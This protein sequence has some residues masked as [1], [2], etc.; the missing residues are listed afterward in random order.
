[1]AY[2]FLLPIYKIQDQITFLNKKY[3]A[4]SLPLSSQE[5]NGEP[6]E[7]SLKN[8]LVESMKEED[9]R[10]KKVFYEWVNERPKDWVELSEISPVLISAIVVSEDAKFA[11][12]LGIDGQELEKVILEYVNAQG[13][14]SE[15]QKLRGAS[16]ISQQLV[17]NLFLSSKKDVTRKGREILMS[18]YLESKVP[19]WKILETYLNIIEYGKDLYGIK[20]ASEFY[21]KK[22]PKDL[23]AREAAFLAMLLPSPVRYSVSFKQK[24]LTAFASNIVNSILF[25]MLQE[26]YIGQD[27]YLHQLKSRFDWEIYA[28]EQNTSDDI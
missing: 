24:K 2:K 8:E 22:S 16:T 26:G 7:E 10:K 19:K 12:H 4:V 5:A 15:S 28:K 3:V 27:E 11:D 1:M 25:K 6:L 17:K 9:S 21:F 13:K 14:E 20:D 23:E 18:L